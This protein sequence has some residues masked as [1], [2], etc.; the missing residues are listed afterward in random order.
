MKIDVEGAEAQVLQ[1][2]AETLRAAK[3]ALL[4]STHG[5]QAKED[6]FRILSDL[7][8]GKPKPLDHASL[9]D[10]NEFALTA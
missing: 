1:G 8:Y 3:P 4:L 7:G 10:A 5:D 9:A 2:A 6:C